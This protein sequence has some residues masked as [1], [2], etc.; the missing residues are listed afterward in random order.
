ML[1]Q[2]RMQQQLRQKF[3]SP[4][5]IL[6]GMTTNASVFS[7]VCIE[8][9]LLPA[10]QSSDPDDSDPERSKSLD[11]LQDLSVNKCKINA[12]KRKN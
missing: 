11:C 9:I 7:F 5:Q 6:Q 8:H 4:Q 12:I 1:L 10:L 3:L 2:Q